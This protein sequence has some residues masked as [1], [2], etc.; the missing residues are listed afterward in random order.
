MP[1][2]NSFTLEHSEIE[3]GIE[4]HQRM[5]G[6]HAIRLGEPHFGMNLWFGSHEH[7]L[8]V[9]RNTRLVHGMI[10][11]N[12][13]NMRVVRASKGWQG[14]LL[15][16]V[17]RKLDFP[18]EPHAPDLRYSAGAEGIKPVVFVGRPQEYAIREAL[19]SIPN[20]GRLFVIDR[21][22]AVGLVTCLDGRPAMR[23]ASYD[24]VVDH[25]VLK[26]ESTE[27]AKTL[28]WVSETLKRLGSPS[29]RR[30]AVKLARLERI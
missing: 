20:G 28:L 23:P 26:G 13:H 18:F 8:P 15:R 16:V 9:W 19:Y 3:E 22:C 10:S 30:F 17:A 6:K 25:V 21:K 2:P 14:A 1:R 4:I 24:E 12:G 5:P 27:N 11:H 29:R 7:G